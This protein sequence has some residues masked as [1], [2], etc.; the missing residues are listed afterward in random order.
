MKSQ[1]KLIMTVLVAFAALLAGSAS[2]SA[3]T[4]K[5]GSFRTIGY[6]K[7]DG[8]VQ[9][10]SYRTVGHI[11][12]DGTVQDGSYRTVGH[13]KNDGTVQD[14]SYRT[15]GHVSGVKKRWVAVYF[16]FGLF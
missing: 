1:L 15:I 7:T 13:V 10:A 6:I 9:N 12:S 8:T 11:K 14:G 2:L 4:V 3:Q 5:D 16:F